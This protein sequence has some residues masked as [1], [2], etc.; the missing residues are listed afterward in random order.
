V[1]IQLGLKRRTLDCMGLLVLLVL[2][3]QRRLMLLLLQ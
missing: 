1:D 3:L 2:P